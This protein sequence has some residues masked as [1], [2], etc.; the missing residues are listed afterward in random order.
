MRYRELSHLR[1]YGYSTE[2]DWVP[3]SHTGVTRSGT[4][5]IFFNAGGLILYFDRRVAIED[6]ISAAAGTVAASY[7]TTYLLSSLEGAVFAATAGVE[8]SA[9]A[10]TIGVEATVAEEELEGLAA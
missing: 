6:I 2:W 3:S 5:I 1:P 4:P 10:A 7:L 9:A 8:L